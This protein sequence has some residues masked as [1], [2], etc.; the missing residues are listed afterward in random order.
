MIRI[1]ADDGKTILCEGNNQSI[2]QHQNGV[3]TLE[4]KGDSVFKGYLNRK[5]AT[6]E[7]F[8]SDGWFKTGISLGFFYFSMKYKIN[9]FFVISISFSF[10][11]KIFF[12]T[13]IT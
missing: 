13:K 5:D 6:E 2:T 8:T 12:R 4:I 1:I 7:S 11:L 3:G 10:M 9:Y